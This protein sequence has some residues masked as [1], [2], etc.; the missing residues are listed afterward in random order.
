MANINSDPRKIELIKAHWPFENWRRV[1]MLGSG[2]FGIVYS[3]VN[4]DAGTFPCAVKAVFLSAANET[5]LKTKTDS[6]INEVKRLS[7]LADCSHI[8]QI[9]DH[10]VWREE[11]TSEAILYLR[12]RRL[13]VPEIPDRD[14][15]I[16]K[17]LV[18]ADHL[19]IGLAHAHRAGIC[20][21]D[22]KPANILFAGDLAGYQLS[23]FGNSAR[24]LDGPVPAG[25]TKNYMAPEAWSA[26]QDQDNKS[27]YD[28]QRSDLYSLGMTFYYYLNGCCLPFGFE[29]SFHR[30]V[31]LR[32]ELPVPKHSTTELTAFLQKLLAYDPSKRY[33]SAEEA[34]AALR[35]LLASFSDV[36][37]ADVS[38][39]PQ[40]YICAL[41]KKYSLSHHVTTP[42]FFLE[43][44]RDAEIRQIKDAFDGGTNPIVL[45]GTR[46]VGKTETAI[47]AA[48]KLRHGNVYLLR[49]HESV[50]KTVMDMKIIGYSFCP[51]MEMVS[52]AELEEQE[53]RQRLDILTQ[54]F[55][56]DT[57]IIDNFENGERTFAQLR[58]EPEFRELVS[59]GIRL[60]IT[61]CT[62]PE[63]GIPIRE[64]CEDQLLRI[65]RKNCPEKYASNEDLRKLIRAVYGNTLAAVIIAK[66]LKYSHKTVTPDD[67]LFGLTS[68]GLSQLKTPAVTTDY[69]REYQSQ[70]IYETLSR[71][72]DISRLSSGGKKVLQF[73]AL[74]P[75]EG[76]SFDVFFDCLN[77]QEQENFMRLLACGWISADE[78][79]QH[80]TVHPLIRDIAH[81]NEQL[82]VSETDCFLQL[83]IR[84][85]EDKNTSNDILY[86]VGEA[87]RTA[88]T[89]VSPHDELGK[90]A[91]V[92]WL[93]TAGSLC[94]RLGRYSEA[95]QRDQTAMLLKGS[96]E[97]R[98]PV[99]GDFGLYTLKRYSARN[100]LL[101]CKEFVSFWNDHTRKSLELPVPEVP[102][103]EDIRQLRKMAKEYEAILLGIR[104]EWTAQT[105]SFPKYNC[106]WLFAELGYFE[107][108]MQYLLQ[109]INDE[110][111]TDC[112]TPDEM[113]ISLLL[114]LTGEVTGGQL[115]LQKQLDYEMASFTAYEKV[116]LAGL[117]LDGGGR[118]RQ[119]CRITA[120]LFQLGRYEEAKTWGEKTRMPE[121]PGFP[122]SEDQVAIEKLLPQIDAKLRCKR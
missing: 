48:Q 58:S 81:E 113:E 74:F 90:N 77:A 120:L 98:L 83:L 34:H 18:M 14:S 4:K 102:L 104:E 82:K 110:T 23:D 70:D 27:V 65:M 85:S 45:Y 60:L 44:S 99:R 33:A 68:T 40:S 7:E 61:T 109:G 29:E 38:L 57:F 11:G 42:D 115:G 97:H 52:L 46:G 117:I 121:P 25:G 84:R 43:G 101:Q 96:S 107:I 116:R 50:R 3:A 15:C 41:P 49:Y 63:T 12:M 2:Q 89:H 71:V 6:A 119:L 1:R 35:G 54:D 80:L 32:E 28:W 91:A 10:S 26:Y 106:A 86:S 103:P 114:R 112:E 51:K 22:I 118:F 69:N 39:Q 72:Y 30:R 20:H 108:A 55:A 73:A 62:V 17:V 19:L 67:L 37:V 16:N 66:T 59:T 87:L 5:L 76:I 92:I 105:D 122:F 94:L 95:I 31:E 88:A 75:L 8:V 47:R 64:L 53:Y 36:E 100:Y 78:E 56:G 21:G 9:H 24:A 13:A 111:A 93:S 79:E